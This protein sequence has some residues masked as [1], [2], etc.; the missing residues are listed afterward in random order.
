MWLLLPAQ[1]AAV[2]FALLELSQTKHDKWVLTASA[3]VAA[4]FLAALVAHR[5]LYLN[6]PRAKY[7][8]EFY[9]WMSLG[10]VLGAC[11]PR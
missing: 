1:L 8:T 2:I 5:T 10:G 9:L 3:G 6:R 7:L 4:F 11:S